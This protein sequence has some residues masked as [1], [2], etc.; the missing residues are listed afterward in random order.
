MIFELTKNGD[1]TWTGDHGSRFQLRRRSFSGGEP[2]S[3]RQRGLLWHHLRAALTINAR[4]QSEGCGTVYRLSFASGS[5]KLTTLYDFAGGP[6][7][8]NP[9]AGL[10]LGPRWHCSAPTYSG[11]ASP[12]CPNA[13]CGTVFELSPTTGT[14]WKRKFSICSAFQAVKGNGRRQV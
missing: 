14:V 10:V 7:G 3:R 11:G 12:A 9:V 13:D 6:D 8:G 5:W 4:P 1:G 2:R